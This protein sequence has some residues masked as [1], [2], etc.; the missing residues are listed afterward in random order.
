MA[1]Y[2]KPIVGKTIKKL[3][4]GFCKDI[5]KDM[6][7][8]FQNVLKQITFPEG[9]AFCP[10]PLHFLRKNERGFNQA[11]IIAEEFSIVTEI[12]IAQLLKRKRNT[13]RQTKLS[14]EKRRQ[15]L[16]GAFCLRKKG[17]DLV[18]KTTPILLVDDVTTT[19]STLD[20][21]ARTLKK[22]GYKNVYGVV[23]ARKMMNM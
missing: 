23:I 4:F 17:E 16:K 14:G 11:R 9:A 6:R 10:V 1:D 3:K 2:Q 20:E 22:C 19:F 12:P 18:T 8:L 21:C 13:L 7:P 15:N 5:L